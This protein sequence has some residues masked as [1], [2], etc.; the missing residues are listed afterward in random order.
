MEDF[1]RIIKAERVKKDITQIEVA[2]RIN[3][4]LFLYQKYEN[5][6]DQMPLGIFNK[7]NEILDNQ[8][9]PFFLQILDT[10]CINK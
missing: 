2:N 4:S 6:P 1:T 10:K 9:A 5:N 7:L 8:L 3:I